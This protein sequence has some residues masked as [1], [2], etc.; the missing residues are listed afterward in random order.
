[1]KALENNLY[2]EKPEKRRNLLKEQCSLNIVYLQKDTLKLMNP[3]QKKDFLESKYL[4]IEHILNKNKEEKIQTEDAKLEELIN[5]QDEKT[6][7]NIPTKNNT[8][9]SDPIF[10]N[11][12]K[13]L[14]DTSK[15]KNIKLFDYSEN[16]D[17]IIRIQTLFRSLQGQKKFRILKYVTHKII[18]I[19][20]RIKGLVI[21]KKFNFFVK[22][23]KSV[24]LIQKLYKKRYKKIVENAKK[25]QRYYRYKKK[26]RA[27]RDKIILKKK[28]ELEKEKFSYINVDK[29][30]DK[31]INNN[32]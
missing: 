3:E 10:F 16:V 19:Q 17:L 6:K 12:V 24:L 21:R 25:I 5:Y 15:S 28:L 27:E 9:V 7:R 8:I 18:Q 13:N 14:F 4:N 22:C 11:R 1:M 20:K 30:M 29:V 26:D 23:Q 31:M 32:N 2:K